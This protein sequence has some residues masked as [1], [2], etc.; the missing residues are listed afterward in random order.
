MPLNSKKIYNNSAPWSSMST[1]ILQNLF[2]LISTVSCEFGLFPCKRP[3]DIRYFKYE[4]FRGKC[5][6]AAPP[7]ERYLP[8]S[9]QYQFL[10]RCI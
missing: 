5:G 7:I 8:I 9:N 10:S 3:R 2:C 1:K 4:T 6:I